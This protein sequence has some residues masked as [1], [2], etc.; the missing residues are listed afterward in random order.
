MLKDN[1]VLV[2]AL[3]SFLMITLPLTSFVQNNGSEDEF[4]EEIEDIELEKKSAEN[5]HDFYTETFIDDASFFN[6]R[7]PV[8]LSIG[9]YH[10]CVVFDDGSL[11]CAGY[12]SYGQLGLGEITPSPHKQNNHQ[13]V[14]LPDDIRITDVEV[15]QYSS[16]AIDE[17]ADIWCWGNNRGYVFGTGFTESY[18]PKPMK[19]RGLENITAEKIHIGEKLTK[20]YVH[21]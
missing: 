18:Q 3:L 19:V 2:V 4:Q 10:S 7:R 1:R 5:N 14:M 13:R 21:F 12:D 15:D 16:C 8:D 9:Y 11:E 20:L 17:N 6:T